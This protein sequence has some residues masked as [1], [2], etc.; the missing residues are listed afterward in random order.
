M[1]DTT[2]K[3]VVNFARENDINTI[4]IASVTGSSLETLCA[5]FDGNIVCVTH[6][7]GYATPG[8]CEFPDELR[9]KYIAQGVKFV[10]AAHALSGAERGLSN[11][12]KGVYPVELIANTLRMF[13]AGTKVC[14]ECAVMALDAGQIAFG[15]KI[16]AVGGTGR[17]L[18]TAL[19]LTPG[20]SHR[21]FS[22][23]IHK[24]ICKP[25]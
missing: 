4:V 11:V 16:I 12:Y 22:T 9:A 17:G 8:T 25:E 14:V 1:T 6:A 13:G 7:Y 18:D 3:T 5:N 15:T 24:T 23:R 20:Y 2:I 19:L 21:I 10:T